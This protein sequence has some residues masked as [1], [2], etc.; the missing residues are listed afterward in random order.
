[1]GDSRVGSAR[2][3]VLGVGGRARG[4]E[5]RSRAR[6][7]KLRVGR[8]AARR[9]AAAAVG[10]RAGVRAARRPSAATGS[11]SKA[12]A[13]DRISAAFRSRRCGAHV[14]RRATLELDVGRKHGPATVRKVIDAV[15]LV[16]GLRGEHRPD[17]RRVRTSSCGCR[18]DQFAAT[19]ERIQGFGKERGLEVHGQDVTAEVTDLEA[20]LRNLR[21]QEAIL[22]DLMRKARNDRRLD[23]GATAALAEPGADRAARRV[24]GACS[25]TRRP[26]RPSPSPIT[27][28]GA[29]VAGADSGRDASRLHGTTR[30]MRHSRSTGGVA[31]SCSARSCRSSCWP[32]SR[33]W[34][35]GWWRVRCGRTSRPAR[36]WPGR[37][38]GPLPVRRARSVRSRR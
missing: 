12:P 2:C 6:R 34:R 14:V 37:R 20:R 1:M 17:R 15:E 30:S 9:R 28:K 7:R 8:P 21:A 33:R 35:R 25:T 23:R 27:P 38:R 22:L 29:P 32:G 10:A 36:S 24:S 11:G 31:R 5:R 3:A 4:G 26:T 19:L 16:G 18:S 13:A